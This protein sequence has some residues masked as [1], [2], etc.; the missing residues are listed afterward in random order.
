MQITVT[1]F[2]AKCL[3]LI[4]EVSK[5]GSV[6]EISKHG[7]PVAKIVPIQAERPW[8]QLR[9]VGRFKGDAMAPVI[10]SAEIEALK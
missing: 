7:K 8:E 3:R 9:G 4:D 5:T 2:K 1:E 6:L 10:S